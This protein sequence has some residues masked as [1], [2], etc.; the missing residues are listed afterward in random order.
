MIGLEQLDFHSTP[1]STKVTHTHT[2]TPS[3]QSPAF[4]M[5]RCVIQRLPSFKSLLLFI[6]APDSLSLSLL[7]TLS[8]SHFFHNF[9]FSFFFPAIPPSSYPHLQSCCVLFPGF[10]SCPEGGVMGK[11][12]LSL[13]GL[14]HSFSFSLLSSTFLLLP[15]PLFVQPFPYSHPTSQ[16]LHF[17]NYRSLS[18]FRSSLLPS[19]PPSTFLENLQAFIHVMIIRSHTVQAQTGNGP[20]NLRSSS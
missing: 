3:S 19:Y 13:L 7:K 2:Y 9:C 6:P 4:T 15:C 20:S 1:S 14:S 5:L 16:S 11:A 17:Y 8:L 12:L 10:S 18:F